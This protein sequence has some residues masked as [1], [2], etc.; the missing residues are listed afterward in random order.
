M[1]DREMLW[2]FAIAIVVLVIWYTLEWHKEKSGNGDD[3]TDH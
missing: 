1:H 2:N 3:Q